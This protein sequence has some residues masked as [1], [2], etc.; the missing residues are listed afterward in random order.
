MKKRIGILMNC[1]GEEIQGFLC[2]IKEVVQT[3]DI[4]YIPTHLHLKTDEGL[5][6]LYLCDIILLNNVKHYKHL[7][8]DSISKK[9]KQG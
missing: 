4:V 5:S 1:H 3:Y 2:R 6:P 9:M 7:T 8:C